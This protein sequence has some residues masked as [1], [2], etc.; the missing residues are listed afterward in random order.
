MNYHETDPEKTF[1]LELAELIGTPHTDQEAFRQHLVEL[2]T[3]GGL[4]EDVISAL[5]TH[6]QE[7]NQPEAMYQFA[8]FHHLIQ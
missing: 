6:L 2:A 7:H 8:L 5:L 1:S 4:S 3:A